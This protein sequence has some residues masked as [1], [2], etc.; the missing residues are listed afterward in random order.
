M[1]RIVVALR[2]FPIMMAAVFFV[3]LAPVVADEPRWPRPTASDHRRVMHFVDEQGRERPVTSPAEWA[4]RRKDVLIGLKAAM[5]ELPDRSQLGPPAARRVP[6]SRVVEQGVAREK[7]LFDGGDDDQIPAWLLTPESASGRTPAILALH[8]TNGAL[9]KDEV[10]GLSG[11]K[12]LHYGIELARRGFVVLAPDYPTLG[13]YRFN[14]ER[15]RF[16]SGSLKGVWN[17]MRCVDWLAAQPNVDVDRIDAIGHSLGGHNAIFLAVYDERIKAIV[18]SCG[19]TPFHDYY[20]GRI[21][22]WSG[23]RYMPRLRTEF[24]LNAD[25]VPFDFQELIAALAPRGC[26]SSSPVNDD[27]FD[28]RGVRKAMAE[29]S[30]V[31]RLLESSDRWQLVTPDCGHDFPPETREA[32][33]QFLEDVLSIRA[34]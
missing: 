27:N 11:S 5:G 15:D 23:E 3:V 20:G 6:S 19:W 32:A 21:A 25:R 30:Q 8:Q 17:H 18:T 33:Y 9:G 34:K 13:E 7:W 1:S 29:S 31:Y 24:A 16:A 10:V 12:N 28:V 4:L 22:G 2:S 26:F 14:F